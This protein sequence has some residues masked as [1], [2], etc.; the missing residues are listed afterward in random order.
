[1]LT[2]RRWVRITPSGAMIDGCPVRVEPTADP[3]LVALYRQRVGSYPKFFKMDP[4]SRLGF[5]ASELL[6]EDETSRFIPRDDRAV[7]LFSRSGSFASDSHF[8]R[9]IADPAEYYPSPAVFVYTLANIVTGE[10]AIR[11]KYYGETIC[12][13][14][15][16]DQPQIIAQTVREAFLDSGTRSV[17]CGWVDSPDAESFEAEMFQV[18]PSDEGVEWSVESICNVMNYK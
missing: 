2:I 11:N 5:I 18:E 15:G 8:E 4:M 6:L 17:L 10:I 14:I 16:R 7:I 12:Y 1:M 9:T 13:L 3:L